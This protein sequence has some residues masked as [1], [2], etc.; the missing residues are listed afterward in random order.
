MTDIGGVFPEKNK[1]NE[2][3]VNDIYQNSESKQIKQKMFFQNIEC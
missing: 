2:C 1:R 3:H